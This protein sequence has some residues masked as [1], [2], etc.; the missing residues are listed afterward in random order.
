MNDLQNSTQP[1]QFRY[2]QIPNFLMEDPRYNDI[3]NT[4]KLLYAILLSRHSLSKKSF[5][6]KGLFKDD[7]GIYVIFTR[8]ELATWLRVSCRTVKKYVDELAIKNLISE[9]RL[10]HCK[11]NRIYVREP[12]DILTAT[13]A[14]Q[15]KPDDHCVNKINV[16]GNILRTATSSDH[17]MQEISDHEQKNF[18]SSDLDT[19]DFDLN[20]SSF[21]QKTNPNNTILNDKN[22]DRQTKKGKKLSN[23][24]VVKQISASNRKHARI[25]KSNN[26]PVYL[27][28]NCY[29]T[30]FDS[31]QEIHTVS[32]CYP[33]TR[34]EIR[35]QISYSEFLLSGESSQSDES[36]WYDNMSLIDQ[37]VEVMA[38]VYD[39]PVGS[40]F[41]IKGFS[42]D[43][44]RVKEEFMNLNRDCIKYVCY[45]LKKAGQIKNLQAYF[46]TTLF[47]A[48]T[49][50]KYALQQNRWHDIDDYH[51]PVFESSDKNCTNGT[52]WIDYLDENDPFDSRHD[53]SQHSYES[54]EK[55]C[56][57]LD[58]LTARSDYLMPF[59]RCQDDTPYNF[60]YA[61]IQRSYTSQLHSLQANGESH[62]IPSL[63]ERIDKMEVDDFCAMVFTLDKNID[64]ARYLKDYIFSLILDSLPVGDYEI[65]I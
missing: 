20:D 46:I 4:G 36:D 56:N 40:M 27:D 50:Y 41:K 33:K 8:Q 47:L 38:T 51:A 61:M 52:S 59:T 55:I 24:P 7:R 21:F 57:L 26:I 3:S 34:Q 65:A 60:I 37:I 45:N 29:S 25:D 18:L 39:S 5:A 62:Y 44:E 22:N 53:P 48:P 32:L 23:S 16:A 64:N 6:E 42:Y 35:Q 15:N 28:Q 2:K 14:E 10:G 31:H 63:R 49:E 58:S 9:K 1:D 19:N 13:L 11:A 43:S 17:E 12:S 30:M 54:H